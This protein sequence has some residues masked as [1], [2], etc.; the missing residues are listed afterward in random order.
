MSAVLVQ[1][2]CLFLFCHFNGYQHAITYFLSGVSACSDNETIEAAFQ[3]GI[4]AFIPKPFNLQTF[5][6]T[7]QNL[8]TVKLMGRDDQSTNLFEERAVKTF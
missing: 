6:S 1:S 7:Y 8:V 5:H 2:I 3:S 4:D